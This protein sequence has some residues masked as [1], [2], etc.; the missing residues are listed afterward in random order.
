MKDTKTLNVSRAL[1]RIVKTRAADAD[2][3]IGD[4]TDVLLQ[5]GLS[6]PEEV[7]QLLEGSTT[8]AES[9]ASE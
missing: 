5:V 8:Q 1:H 4:Y 7:K 9:Q 6:H 2:C 3:P